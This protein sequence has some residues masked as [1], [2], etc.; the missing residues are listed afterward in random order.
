MNVSR[1]LAA[2]FLA[3]SMSQPAL[4]QNFPNKPVRLIIPF[5]PGSASDVVGRAVALT[6]ADVWGQ[7][8]VAE[9]RPGA[10][11][12]I[13]ALQVVK[14]APDGYTLLANTRA[15]AAGPAIYASLPFDTLKDFTH[16]APLAGQANVLIVGANQGYRTLKDFIA[17]A[18]AKPGTLNFSSAGIGS[19][20]HLNLEQFKLM[21]GI[22]VVHVPYKGT[23]EAVADTI[24]DRV[25]C[26]FAPVASAV[27]HIQAG[28]AI[29]L[30]VSS[31][32]RSALLPNVPSIAEAG[33]PGFDYTL[34]TG[35]WGPAGLPSALA[36]QINRDVQR[37]LATPELKERLARL[38]AE[39][40]QMGVAEFTK[41][42]RDQV[43]ESQRIIKAAGIKP[44]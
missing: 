13:G 31:A 39:P 16:V 25:C 42:M 1:I 29:A 30:G 41:Y 40:M 22:D 9:N 5:T 17:A 43:E 28:K 20:T 11:G 27:A 3:L 15:L 14:S 23:P 44:Q 10:G 8:V 38:G 36:E 26:Y 32:K 33:V 21:A 7:P 18:K 35:L 24:A 2:G 37:A 12:S 4:A 34:W 19:G 6:L